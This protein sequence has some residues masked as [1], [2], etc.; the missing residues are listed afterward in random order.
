M[1][2]LRESNR[3][4][5]TWDARITRIER[6]LADMLWGC[7]AEGFLT[8]ATPRFIRANPFNTRDPRVRRS[9]ELTA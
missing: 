5:G 7:P 2:P 9:E 3:P 6:I 8:L 1:V 4:L